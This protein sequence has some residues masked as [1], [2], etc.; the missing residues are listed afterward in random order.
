MI[1]SALRH[2]PVRGVVLLA[3]LVAG[4]V[5]PGGVRGESVDPASAQHAGPRMDSVRVP[6]LVIPGWFDTVEALAGLRARLRAA[7][8]PPERVA[9]VTFADPVGSNV[10]HAREIGD[11]VTALRE[12][13]GAERVDLIAHSMGGLAARLYMTSHPGTVRRVVFLATP[14]RGTLSAYL[15]FGE[16]RDEMLPGSEFLET[17]NAH[18]AVPAGVAALTVRTWLDTHVIP[19]ASATLPGVR[20]VVVCCASHEG[21]TRDLTAFNAIAAF[22]KAG[23]V[24]P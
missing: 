10:A 8:W 16:G 4:V 13:T 14:H 2:G 19:G 23:G 9:G 21:L 24:G 22:L 1:R 15:A 6:V 5:V 12:R 11:A 3:A 7:G 17:L 18:P 20:D